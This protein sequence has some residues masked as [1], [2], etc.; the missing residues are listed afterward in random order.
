MIFIYERE[1]GEFA[2][3]NRAEDAVKDTASKAKV[4]HKPV[5]KLG[6]NFVLSQRQQTKLKINPTE[7]SFV[8]RRLKCLQYVDLSKLNGAF[9]YGEV[10][11]ME[12]KR[13]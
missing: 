2:V 11:L 5:W 13:T 12:C 8:M 7:C 6:R 10:S 4:V 9:I 1:Q 3:S